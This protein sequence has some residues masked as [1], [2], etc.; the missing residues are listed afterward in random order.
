MALPLERG[1]LDRPETPNLLQRLRSTF[2]FQRAVF[3]NV[4]L[5]KLGASFELVAAPGVQGMT[6]LAACTIVA[7]NYLPLARVLADSFHLHHPE[8]NFTIV[9]VDRPVEA[10]LIRGDN[11]DVLPITD[12]DFG[13]DGFADMAMIYDV[14]EFAT[15]VKPFAL[16][17]LLRSHDCVLYLDPDIKLFAR[18]DPLVQATVASGWS[19]TPHCLQP[20]CRDGTGPT[21]H[22]IMQ[23]GIYNLGYIGVTRSASGLLDWWAERLRRDSISDPRNHLFTDQRW[24]DLAVPIFSPYVERSASYNVAYWNVDQRRLWR[25]GDTLMVNEDVLRFFHFSGYDPDKPHWLSKH[26]THRPRVLMSE[27]QLL[28]EICSAYGEEV[29]AHRPADSEI[30]PY[31]WAEAMPGLPLSRGIRRIFRN[32][33]LEAE[34]TGDDR[35]PSPF[36]PGGSERFLDWLNG[37][38]AT[39]PRRLPRFLGVLY[40]ERDD[41]QRN[42]P[43]VARGNLDEFGD[44]VRTA[45]AGWVTKSRAYEHAAIGLL[46]AAWQPGAHRKVSD[47]GRLAH[48]VDVIGYLHAELG[49]G[50]AGRLLVTGLQAA[51]IPV[52]PIACRRTSSRQEHPFPTVDEARYDTVIMAVNADQVE[53]VGQD[54]GSPF[55]E[56]RRVIGQWFW[57]L[58]EFPAQFRTA[59]TMV[60]EVWAATEFMRAAIAAQAPADVPVH[61]VPL[62]LVTPK[63]AD[64]TGKATFGLGRQFTFLFSFDFMSVLER[65]NPLGLVRAFK[66]AFRPEEGPVLVLKTINGEKRLDWI[67][68]LRWE[69]RDRTDIVLMDGYLDAPMTASLMAA[70][71]CY[72][73]LHRSEGLGLTIAEAMALGKPV[74]ATAYSGNLDFMTEKCAVLLPWERIV[75]GESAPPYSPTATWADPNLDAAA[76]AMRRMVDEPARAARLGA[77]AAHHLATNFSPEAVGV[78]MRKRLNAT[79]RNRHE[80]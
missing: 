26:V 76:L 46:G 36:R 53:Q 31:G 50:E 8:A 55:F 28:S 66:Q 6:T 34:C 70:C 61:R 60:D 39:D 56:G 67:E 68:R 78:I 10:R 24:I 21:E 74:I 42:F 40:E 29:R 65:K 12:I 20:I 11:F 49:V 38:P 32:E 80:A 69:C 75:V 54:F 63:V 44:W 41:F 17:H 9:V 18:L 73:S 33:L 51:K 59:F 3:E 52:G 77:A 4:A 25:D 79:R 57:E 16:Q 19:L 72:V 22:D 64:G 27:N 7:S 35:P 71:D 43:G 45:G 1:S 37:V 15:A 47:A 48:G 2:W 30:P 5:R 23:A 62:P 58:D 14:T 13:G